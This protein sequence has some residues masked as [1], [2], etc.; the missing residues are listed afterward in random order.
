MNS[1]LEEGKTLP[2]QMQ[3]R[4]V[5]AV[6][7]PGPCCALTYRKNAEPTKRKMAL[8]IEGC[9]TNSESSLGRQVELTTASMYFPDR[10]SLTEAAW[11]IWVRARLASL[12]PKLAHL[13]RRGAR[14]VAA[15]CR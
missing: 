14:E 8:T 6:N 9:S 12:I 11:S 10:I 4:I 7:G 1:S 3:A 5:A 15:A 2:R 13:C